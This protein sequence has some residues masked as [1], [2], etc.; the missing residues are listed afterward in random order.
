[1]NNS[2]QNF[3]PYSDN[4]PRLTATPTSWPSYLRDSPPFLPNYNF[5]ESFHQ[6]NA[7][8]RN[9]TLP[10][11]IDSSGS[12]YLGNTTFNDSNYSTQQM[13]FI[14]ENSLNQ[15]SNR[16]NEVN[17]EEEVKNKKKLSNRKS[18]AYEREHKDEIEKSHIR[19][20][21]LVHE[22]KQQFQFWNGEKF[23]IKRL[24][25]K[26]CI[27][28]ETC[29]VKERRQRNASQK[30]N[31]SKGPSNSVASSNVFPND[32]PVRS[33][34]CLICSSPNIE[35]HSSFELHCDIRSI[36]CEDSD[37]NDNIS[38]VSQDNSDSESESSDAFSEIGKLLSLLL[39]LET[40][41]NDEKLWG[42]SST[43]DTSDTESESAADDTPGFEEFL[44]S[45]LRVTLKT[46]QNKNEEE[47]K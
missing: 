34:Q 1:M 10:Y 29:P 41:V 17:E 3:S 38:D 33:N 30:T 24:L 37:Y 45:F 31:F 14:N 7:N 44:N 11:Y 2:G 6:E 5:N 19:N 32:V 26:L 12:E 16:N 18:K 28:Y 21:K 27:E 4:L 8:E 39:N 47:E 40:A 36:K 25:R 20:D 43:E 46:T 23:H 9:S 22:I 35:Y 13:N 15:L 42:Q